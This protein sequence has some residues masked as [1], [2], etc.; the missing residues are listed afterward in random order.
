MEDDSEDVSGRG[1]LGLGSSRM[2]IDESEPGE[3]GSTT[4][5]EGI[6]STQGSMMLESMLDEML[7]IKFSSTKGKG[8]SQNGTK[9][10]A[11]SRHS[12]AVNKEFG[13]F[14]KHTK[15]IG[16]KLMQ[17]MGY[18]VVSKRSTCYLA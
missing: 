6:S 5:K 16:L 14:E 12:P 15:G 11:S 18:K 9:F 3:G 4:K 10:Q 13:N 17:K 1:G 2:D 7:N 8:K